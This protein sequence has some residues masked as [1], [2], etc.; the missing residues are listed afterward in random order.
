MSWRETTLGLCAKFVSGGTPKK[1]VPEYWNGDIPWVG[2]GEM[3][4]TFLRDTALRVT[5]EGAE[6][7][8]RLVPANTVL[9]VVRGMSLAKE[10]RISLTMREMT[11]NQD[12]KALICAEGIKPKFLFY[13]L[14]ARKDHIRDLATDA[15]HGTKKLE[16]D[17]LK[18]VAI[19]LPDDLDVQDRVVTILSAYDDLIENNRRRIAL[20]EQAARLLYREWFV[21]LRFPDHES[22][23]IVDGLPEGWERK[24][25]RDLLQPLKAKP[26]IQKGEYQI[27]GQYPCVDQGQAFVG[28]YTDNVEAVYR[29]ELPLIVFGDH[30]RSLKFID[31]P[32]ARGADG[33]QIIKSSHNRLSQ[34]Q[35]YFALVE[36]D[37]SNYFYARHFK[38]LKDQEIVIPDESTGANFTVITRSMFSQIGA[39]NRQIIELTRARDLLLP[40]LMDGRVPV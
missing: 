12:V 32:F 29:D 19:K 35:L 4:E 39:L 16:T 13:A 38:F 21:H 27:A 11:F 3:S 8:S 31:F 7:G 18:A 33:T 15:S 25:V 30:T 20:L 9:V 1:A 5:R 24:K 28:G 34:E 40:R 17:Q 2:S 10:F 14:K 23:K 6:N 26:K 37:L 36:V 22:A